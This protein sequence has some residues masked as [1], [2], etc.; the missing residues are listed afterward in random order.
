M[1]QGEDLIQSYENKDDK[2]YL[3]NIIAKRAR[4]IKDGERPVVDPGATVRPSEIA[5]KEMLD[6]KLKVSAKGKP[7]KMVDIVREVSDRS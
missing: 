6:G 2:Y 3:V 5:L 7:N 4:Q 1:K